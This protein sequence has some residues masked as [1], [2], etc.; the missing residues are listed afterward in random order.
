M[1]FRR[2]GGGPSEQAARQSPELREKREQKKKIHAALT[3]ANLEIAAI[4]SA[5]IISSRKANGPNNICDY[6]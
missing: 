4:I 6:G 1:E 3:D 5:V 2:G